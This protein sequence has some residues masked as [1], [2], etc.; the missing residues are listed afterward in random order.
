MRYAAIVIGA[1]ACVCVACAYGPSLEAVEL[2]AFSAVL[3]A[4]ADIDVRTRRIP[5][6]LLLAACAIR[7]A[8]VAAAGLVFGADAALLLARSLA[9][10]LVVGGGLLVATLLADRLLGGQSM[11]GGD[12]KLFAVEGLYFGVS[13][14]L[15][16][17]A[18]S[19]VIG[20][21][22]ALC[23]RGAGGQGG[24]GAKRTFAFAPAIAIAS[25]AVMI[26]SSPLVKIF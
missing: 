25:I 20:A 15:A 14:G 19:C 5:N 13:G 16:V 6:A 21:V 1:L 3:I 26:A 22:S 4:A 9:G 2:V 10:A 24:E 12:I 17:L 11:G 7:L 8:Y 23:L 18:G